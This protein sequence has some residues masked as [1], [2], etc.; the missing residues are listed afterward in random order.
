MLAALGMLAASCAEDIEPS[1]PQENPA[2]PI[3]KV[4]DIEVAKTGELVAPEGETLPSIKLEKYLSSDLVPAVKVEKEDNLPTGG[5]LLLRLEISDTPDFAKSRSIDMTRG[6]GD[7]DSDILYVP[8]SQWSEA[9]IELFGK[10]DAPCHTYYRIPVYVTLAG[11]DYRINNPDYYALSGEADVTRLPFGYVVEDNY[12]VFGTYVGNNTPANAVIMEHNNEVSVYDDPVFTYVF[13][14]DEQQATTG[15]T[16]RI[17]PESVRNNPNGTPEQCY[18]MG[19]D[20][21]TLELGGEPIVVN[22][23][24]P[25]KLEINMQTLTW[26]VTSAVATLYVP[27]KGASF[28]SPKCLQLPTTDYVNYNGFAWLDTQFRLTGQKGWAPVQYGASADDTATDIVLGSGAWLKLPA[29]SPKG[30]YYMKVSTLKLNYSATAIKSLGLIGSFNN[31]NESADVQ[32]TPDA[33]KTTW[34]ATAT[35][36]A[37]AEF[38]V[39]ANAGWDIQVAAEKGSPAIMPNAAYTN[40]SI[41]KD[42]NDNFKVAEAGTYTVTLDLSKLPYTITLSK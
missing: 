18:G 34:K 14:V 5:E 16:L 8:T 4:D 7:S 32:M 37:G 1:K 23:V 30:L 3:L 17:A 15:Y 40:I 42:N 9:Q 35:F 19:R 28:S 2:E 10:T 6:N 22:E 29:K 25:F 13:T 36:E 31:W 24:G 39:R 33:N 11:T 27:T 12:Y 41:D 20:N 21:G 38:K 26:K